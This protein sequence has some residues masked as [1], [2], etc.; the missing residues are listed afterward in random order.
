V[1]DL[2]SSPSPPDWVLIVNS[3]SPQTAEQAKTETDG[4]Q[5]THIVLSVSRGTAASL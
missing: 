1:H 3:K 4:G 2:Q 5:S